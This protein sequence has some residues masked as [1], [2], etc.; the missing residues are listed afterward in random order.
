MFLD[1]IEDKYAEWIKVYRDGS[2]DPL[3][4]RLGQGYNQITPTLD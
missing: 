1:L 2:H 3:T 4:G